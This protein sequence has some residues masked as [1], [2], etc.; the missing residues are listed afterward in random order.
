MNVPTGLA[1]AAEP[2]Y[3]E[4][5]ARGM[6]NAS[7]IAGGQ[8]ALAFLL[9][10]TSFRCAK[11]ADDGGQVNFKVEI[12]PAQ[13]VPLFPNVRRRGHA[14]RGM[15]QRNDPERQLAIDAAIEAITR[16]SDLVDRVAHAM[17]TS[18]NL[19]AEL[20]SI[21][22]KEGLDTR[23]ARRHIYLKQDEF[24]VHVDK[25]EIPFNSH[26]VRTAAATPGEITLSTTFIPGRS[27]GIVLKGVVEDTTMA[28]PESCASLGSK[29][30]F[31]F[32]GL[33]WWQRTILEA[34]RC[35]Q[36]PVS[37][38][39]RE[40]RSTCTTNFLPLDVVEVLNWEE[41]LQKTFVGLHVVVNAANEATFENR[42]VQAG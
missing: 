38:I 7:V 2:T 24:F 18:R 37:L 14:A 22:E 16:S 10:E 40:T 23:P 29:T 35:L 39:A 19:A 30:E 12:P 26:A 28:D 3:N 32:V 9:D 25:V 34:A 15:L 5:L 41:L 36:L 8:E 6:Q 21:E 13:Q 20:K 11:L 42:N 31:R 33:T 1:L 4:L 27:E 17:A